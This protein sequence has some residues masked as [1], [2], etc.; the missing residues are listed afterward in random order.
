MTLDRNVARIGVMRQESKFL[1]GKCE[2]KKKVKPS[3][4]KLEK[5]EPSFGKMRKEYKFMIG[6]CEGKR[7]IK[8]KKMKLKRN[9]ARM[10]DNRC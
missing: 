9:A 2:E 10:E 6:K 5:N 3:N 8:A 4:I 1:I 7:K